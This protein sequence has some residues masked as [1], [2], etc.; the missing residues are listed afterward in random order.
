VPLVI[1]D[2]AVNTLDVV[3]ELEADLGKPV[4]T[5]NQATLWKGLRL[6]GRPPR[7]PRAGALLTG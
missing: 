6:L 1:A 2:S 5:A 3:A 4:V 7:V